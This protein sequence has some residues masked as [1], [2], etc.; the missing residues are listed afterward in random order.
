LNSSHP[1]DINDDIHLIKVPKKHACKKF[2]AY[3]GDIIFLNIT[4]AHVDGLILCK[5]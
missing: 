3:A 1:E 5:T 2:P 4:P